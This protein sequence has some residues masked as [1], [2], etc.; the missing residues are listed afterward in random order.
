MQKKSRTD[1]IKAHT[2]YII[3][4][5]KEISVNVAAL[6]SNISHFLKEVE[7]GTSVV[8]TSHDKKVGK[9]ISEEQQELKIIPAHKPPKDLKKIKRPHLRNKTN[10]LEM[11]LSDRNQ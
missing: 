9:I 6:R 2:K 3:L 7:T 5:H 4:Q 8:I 11:L 10:P 1:T